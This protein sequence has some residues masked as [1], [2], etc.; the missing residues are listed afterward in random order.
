MGPPVALRWVRALGTGVSPARQ[1]VLPFEAIPQCPGNQWT[2]MLRIWKERG[3]ETLHLEMQKHFQE[4]GPI[5]RYNVGSVPMVNVMLPQ[6]AE[7]LQRVDGLHPYRVPVEPW[8]A[9]RHHHGLTL[10]VFLMNGPEWR[11]VRLRLNPD[12]LE[13][14][15]TRSFMPMVDTVARDFVQALRR[16]V[17][18]NARRSLTLDIQPSV[19]L[20]AMEASNFALYG[21]RL[22]LLGPTPSP[23]SVDFQEA[24]EVMLTSTTQLAFLPPSL[25][26]WASA[27]V[28]AR[29]FQ[30]WDTIFQFANKAMQSIHQ[31]VTLGGPQHYSGIMAEL[32]LKSDLSLDTIKSSAVD[33]TA[34]SVDTTSYSLLMTLFELARTPKVQQALRKESLEAEVAV[35]QSPHRVTSQL[36]LLRAALKE[37]LR[38]YPVGLTVHRRVQSDLVLQ[39]YHIPAGTLVYLYLYSLGRNPGVFPRPERYDPQ[40]WLTKASCDNFR[41]VAFGFGV[42]QCLGRRLA[43]A[44]MLLF[45]HH[46]LKTFQVSTASAGDLEL[47]F[48]FVL[49]PS[50]YP[51]LTFQALPDLTPL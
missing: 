38:L 45:L 14:R 30:A 31:E 21:E 24:M 47:A 32:L 39:N 35:T 3:Q 49:V 9:Y 26:R 11:R 2:R 19:F 23:A 37:T 28:W 33:L 16:R 12:L 8:L 1:A 27:G 7:Q 29:H 48:R 13:P 51:L 36:P 34:G 20:Y 6:H 5:F 15:S 46:V 43:E 10:G 4:L 25:S 41:H 40:R 44:E 22:G 50:A 18:Q 17:L 42:R